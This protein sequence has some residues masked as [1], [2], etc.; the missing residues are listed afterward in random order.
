MN[1]KA[2]IEA[3]KADGML[4]PGKLVNGR[5]KGCN[6][7]GRCAIGALLFHG[8]MTN[9]ELQ[10]ASSDGYCYKYPDPDEPGSEK[11]RRIFTEQYGLTN[12]NIVQVIDGTVRCNDKFKNAWQDEREHGKSAKQ[13]KQRANAVI[14]YIRSL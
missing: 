8:G 12:D 1:K 2:M 10:G 11:G 6:H 3:I 14:R 7:V 5:V 4:C 9:K 13:W